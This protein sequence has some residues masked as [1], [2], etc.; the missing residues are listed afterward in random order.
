MSPR[1]ALVALALA[2]LTAASAFAEQVARYD[3]DV[4]LSA[5]DRFTVEERIT[6]D[7]GFAQKHG[8]ERWIPIRYGRGYAADYR[9]AL[10]L[11]SVT[12]ANGAAL[13]VS[14]RRDGPNLDRKSVV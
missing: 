13:Q 8:I 14:E 4:F 7:F 2:T 9:I 12:D 10:E 1:R 6:Y 3:V 5:S 11:E